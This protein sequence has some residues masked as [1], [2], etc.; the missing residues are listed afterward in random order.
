MAR[1][2]VF[3]GGQQL[4]ALARI[5]RSEVATET[6]EEIIYIGSEAIGRDAARRAIDAADVAV[7][8]TRTT[9]TILSEDM[10]RPGVNLIRV[11]HV[12]ADFLWP[13]AG[14]PHPRNRGEFAI[15]G[16]PYPADFGDSFLDSMMDDNVPEDE[17]VERYG[18]I[19]LA[20]A[21]RVETLREARHATQTRLDDMTGLAL[22][23]F[24]HTNAESNFRVQPLFLSRERPGLPLVRR[25][26]AMVFRRLGAD[27]GR[28]ARV[29]ES[30][31]PGGSLPFHPSVAAHFGLTY[32]P[33]DRRY[34]MNDEGRF[35]FEEYCRR[36]YRFEWNEALHIALA[37]AETNPAGAVAELEAALLR[38]PGSRRGQRALEIA[39]RAA[40]GKT[41]PPPLSTEPEEEAA[42]SNFAPA[43]VP[44]TPLST[45]PVPGTQ[46][47]GTQV[48][49]TQVPATIASN[50]PAIVPANKFLQRA[51][52]PPGTPVE[53]TPFP[54][55]PGAEAPVP[56]SPKIRTT[57]PPP[58]EPIM[59]APAA[60]S[61]FEPQAYVELP[62]FGE[63]DVVL[64]PPPVRDPRLPL[65]PSTDLIQVLPRVLPKPHG[66]VGVTDRPFS[67]MP[68][69]MPPPPL[70]P[71]LP[72]ELPPE[73]PKP[74]L[75]A[76]LLGRGEE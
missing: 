67:A 7:S 11:P 43:I 28:A 51:L 32:L 15:Q 36:Y 73:P 42:S 60:F 34:P 16:G 12:V 5:Y 61:E 25:L 47:P 27:P 56:E 52:A 20:S 17:A 41:A 2:I 40:G 44:T 66:L 62:R 8:E 55:L 70:R 50:L 75:L 68:E 46:V 45:I 29:R 1:R 58:L 19:N 6:D 48:P 14:R 33:E 31:F 22:A 30:P 64:P 35:T 4:R 37:R 21:A 24:I 54:T 57:A 26:T 53:F 49:A 18:T 72:P 39:Q 13:N 65:A 3:A 59:A 10:L 23:D 74:G 63:P 9:G 38:S 69:T 76:R 71:V